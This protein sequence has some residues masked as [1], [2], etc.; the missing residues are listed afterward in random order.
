MKFV[1]LY[2][3]IVVKRVEEKEVKKGSIIIPDT[4]KEKPQKAQVIAVGPGK[5]TEE[6]KVIPLTV[7]V[8]DFVLIGKY[9]GNELRVDDDEYVFLREDEILSKIEE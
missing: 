3:R 2:D 7:K 4:A 8:G 5:T 6:G 1:P 9:A